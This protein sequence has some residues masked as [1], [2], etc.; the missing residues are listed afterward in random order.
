MRNVLVLECVRVCA[1]AQ[2]KE[3][4]ILKCASSYDLFVWAKCQNDHIHTHMNRR[5][6]VELI[7]LD[8][9]RNGYA[10]D[11]DDATDRVTNARI[12]INF[13][14]EEVRKKR[15]QIYAGIT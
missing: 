3:F 5:V 12:Q 15:T 10:Y 13:S 11:D 4:Q 8:F 1:H 9:Y 14:I 6:C 7:L 2:E